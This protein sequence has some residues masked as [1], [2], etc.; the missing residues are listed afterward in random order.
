MGNLVFIAALGVGVVVMVW[1]FVNE[2]RGAEGTLGPF[3]LKDGEGLADPKEDAA[4]AA[5]YR[6]RPRLRP[7]RRAGLHPPAAQ[8]AYRLKEAPRSSRR[9]ENDPEADNDY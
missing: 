2:A 8:K 3:A 7:E 1:Y 6:I 9:G 5:R 4:E